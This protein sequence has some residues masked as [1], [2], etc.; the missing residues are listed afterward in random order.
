MKKLLFSLF[1][2]GLFISAQ[3]QNSLGAKKKTTIAFRLSAFDFGTAEKVQNSSTH[4]RAQGSRAWANA[5]TQTG[6]EHP[7]TVQVVRLP[8]DCQVVRHTDGLCVTDPTASTQPSWR[9]Y[10]YQTLRLR[11]IA[12]PSHKWH[13]TTS[14]S[15]GGWAVSRNYYLHMCILFMV[16]CR[17]FSSQLI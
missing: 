17:R 7:P 5:P 9:V 6:R 12:P 8:A 3:A 14:P 4:I 2:L 16:L 13:R 15:D 11:S 1:A 10:Y